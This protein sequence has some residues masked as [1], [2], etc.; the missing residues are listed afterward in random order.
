VLHLRAANGIIAQAAKLIGVTVATVN[1]SR[2]KLLNH[3]IDVMELLDDESF[4]VPNIELG[5]KAKEVADEI[6]LCYIK[7]A[8]RFFL[9]KTSETTKALGIETYSNYYQML[10]KIGITEK[11]IAD[12]DRKLHKKRTRAEK[13][14]IFFDPQETD[15]EKLKAALA[16]ANASN[17]ELQHTT[18]LLNQQLVQLK[19]NQEKIDILREQAAQNKQGDGEKVI[20]LR[21]H[22]RTQT[23]KLEQRGK[24][25]E[26]L[27]TEL[28]QIQT[29]INSSKEQE[30]QDL[31]NSYKLEISRLKRDLK[32]VKTDIGKAVAETEAKLQKKIDDADAKIADA[33][34]LE[35]RT[36]NLNKRIE[37]LEK[38]RIQLRKR[39]SS[40]Q[41][42]L[43]T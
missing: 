42:I 40:K 16:K 43:R 5:T 39:L 13:I 11:V 37:L 8:Y 25:L 36:E 33:I 21:K 2:K 3:G 10:K 1:E 12:A 41:K 17:N 38:S 20:E 18:V 23:E 7:L 35:K 14:R 26:K 32:K 9:G 22:L 30:L 29:K 4:Q 24:E 15:P 27:R 28:E 19:K 34:E 31:Q 6:R